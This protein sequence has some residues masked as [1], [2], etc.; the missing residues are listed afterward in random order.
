MVNT[1]EIPPVRFDHLLALTGPHGL[2]EHALLATPRVDHG[3]TTD[4]NARALAVLADWPFHEHPPV[5][6]YLQFVVGGRVPLG[7]HNRMTSGGEWIDARGSDDAHGRALWGLG[8]IVASG[9]ASDESVSAFLAGLDLDSS[10][11]RANAYAVLGAVATGKD[12][13][14]IDEV[15]GFLSR[16]VP[17]LARPTVGGWKWPGERLTYDNA[18]LPQALIEAGEALG[19]AGM[20]SDGLELLEWLI[21]V[22]TGARGFSFTPV[23]GRGPGEP[24]PGFD[25]QPIE[26]WAMADAC[27]SAAVADG[28]SQWWE[29]LDAA[30]AWF[31]GENDVGVAILDPEIGAGYDGL[32]P[33]GVNRNCGAESTL[34]ALGSLAAWWSARAESVT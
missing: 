1:M 2:F 19:D 27:A 16:V 11:P 21:S 29:S 5:D 4:D 17:R 10:H 34:A 28:G 33:D 26:A 24:S 8:G 23:G 25:Q 20:V 14:F 7:W 32:Q 15:E 9:K 22:E 18:R 31:V 12:G 6:P 3:Y 13:A 30:V